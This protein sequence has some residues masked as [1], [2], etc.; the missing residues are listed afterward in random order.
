MKLKPLTLASTLA[1]GRCRGFPLALSS[2]E[3]RERTRTGQTIAHL[4]PSA[5]AETITNERLYLSRGAL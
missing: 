4:V 5:V 2:S 3:I 1:L